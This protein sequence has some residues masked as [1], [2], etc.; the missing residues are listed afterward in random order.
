[1]KRHCI[2]LYLYS[3]LAMCLCFGREEHILH[4][5]TTHYDGFWSCCGENRMPSRMQ[6]WITCLLLF[7]VKG[8]MIV[9]V[10]CKS[11][12][13]AIKCA[14]EFAEKHDCSTRWMGTQTNN[15]WYVFVKL[16]NLLCTSTFLV[17]RRDIFFLP[18]PNLSLAFSIFWCAKIANVYGFQYTLPSNLWFYVCAGDLFSQL[19]HL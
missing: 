12:V 15:L 6:T 2:S 4:A 16:L 1:M 14:E 19:E 10:D 11:A 8:F 7:H 18:P 9:V 3:S 17:H 5:L 13:L